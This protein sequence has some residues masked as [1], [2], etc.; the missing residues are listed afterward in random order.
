M[1]N[2]DTYF[3]IENPTEGEYRDKGSRFLAFACPVF[4]GKEIKEFYEILKKE[5]WK[6]NHHCYAYRL[7]VSGNLYRANDDGEP[8]GT[9]GKPILGQ[10]D[11]FGITN[12]L[13]VVLRYFGGIKLGIPG[14]IQA[15]RTAAR[16][17]L[18]HATK[19]E[20]VMETPMQ[21]TFDYAQTSSVMTFLKSSGT[22][23]RNQEHGETNTTLQVLVRLS[24]ADV[25]QSQIEKIENLSVQRFNELPFG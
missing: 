14:L 15:Y 23:I 22:Q 6:A 9:A 21:I 13:I 17:A 19:I 20:R 12:V 25:F 18:E 3:T 16:D 7:G 2:T 1:A 5:H 24:E 8:S 11:S 4:T 10:I